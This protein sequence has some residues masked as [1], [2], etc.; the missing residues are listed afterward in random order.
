MALDPHR[1]VVSGIVWYVS[2]QPAG[3]CGVW[4]E[5]TAFP[6]AP[7]DP[8]AG[9]SPDILILTGADGSYELDLPPATFTITAHGSSPAGKDTWGEVAGVV[10]T[11]DSQGPLQ[12]P[13]PHLN[14]PRPL[15]RAVPRGCIPGSS[16]LQW[17]SP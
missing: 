12:F 16:P 4:G 15:R 3:D 10:V 11:A 13:P 8:L 14:V 6:P 7:P 1:G 9:E 2:G 17:P 5:P